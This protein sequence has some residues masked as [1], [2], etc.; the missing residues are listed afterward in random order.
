MRD[1]VVAI[2]VMVGT[3]TALVCSRCA[4]GEDE[5]VEKA[6]TNRLV[7]EP[8]LTTPAATAEVLDTHPESTATC[9]VWGRG[10]LGERN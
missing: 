8:A 10:L 4:N 2:L 5:A 3:N 6:K 7:Q 9:D 1:G